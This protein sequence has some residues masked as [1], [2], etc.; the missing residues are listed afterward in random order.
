MGESEN[1][2]STE[3][4]WDLPGKDGDPGTFSNGK[5]TVSGA[6]HLLSDAEKEHDDGAFKVPQT[7]F[8]FFWKVARNLMS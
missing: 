8:W 6:S 1:Q 3:D 2:P 4:L 7:V 5:F